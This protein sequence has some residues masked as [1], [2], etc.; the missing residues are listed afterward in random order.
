M[1]CGR[2]LYP[3]LHGSPAGGSTLTMFTPKSERSPA[4]LGPTMKFATSTT[5]SPEKTLS[6]AVALPLDQ[7]A[8]PEQQICPDLVAVG[9]VEHLV[10][11]AW[12]EIV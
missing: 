10:P 7:R 12:I 2:S 1:C 5:F 9:F 6:V 8:Y 4:A 11:T 3:S